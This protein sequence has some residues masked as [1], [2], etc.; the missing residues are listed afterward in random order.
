MM[1]KKEKIVLAFAIILLFIDFLFVLFCNT[2]PNIH[3]KKGTIILALNDSYKEPGYYAIKGFSNM[4]DQVTIKNNI[5]PKKIGHYQVTYSIQFRNKSY[6]KIRHVIVEDQ[7]PPSITLKGNKTAIVCPNKIYQEEGYESIDNYDGDLTNEV[8]VKTKPNFILYSVKDH[9]GNAHST[10]RWIQ[11]EDTEAPT[12][13]LKGG[14]AYSLYIGESYQE[15]GYIATD[16]CDGDITDK[17]V[18]TSNLDT[19]KKGT[20][21]ITYT[22]T[23]NSLKSTKVSRTVIVLGPKPKSGKVIYLTFDDGPSNS[24][25]PALLDILKEENV[26]A[27]FFVLN[28]GSS[29]DYLIKREYEEGH[30][31]ALH[32]NTH[33]YRQI[34]SSS[35]AFF[36]DLSIIQNKVKAITG[37]TPMIIRFP[38][39]SSN[40]ISRFNP[41]IMSTLTKEA[42]N[43]GY[44]YFDWNVGSGDSGDVHTAE[45]VYQNVIRG[46]G[47]N[48][49]V[50]LMHDFNGNYKTLHAI[51][52]I[53]QYGKNHGYKFERI[54]MG[55]P[56]VHHK[57]AN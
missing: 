35:K 31:V 51:K 24:I 45:A 2:I 49:N 12:I 48:N 25:T 44:H 18:I 14:N 36:D 21:E 22:V 40:T 55:T 11:Y 30:T 46:L 1:E 39:G 16:N 9:S 20:Y 32:G 52:K 33:N 19:N 42:K 10:K 34:Y 23:D 37:E 4:T 28:H 13:S 50:I 47:N 53:I 57:V 41:G 8:I 3:L 29:M 56:E 5:N 38:G 7:T 43:R 54:T 27:T 15:P 17:V 6:Q 26:K